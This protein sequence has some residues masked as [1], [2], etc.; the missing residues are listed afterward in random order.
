MAQLAIP[1]AEVHNAAPLL[2]A[3]DHPMFLDYFVGLVGDAAPSRVLNKA[4]SFTELAA[5][6]ETNSDVDLVFMDLS[7]PDIRGLFGLLY[8]KTRYPH[9]RFAVVSGNSSRKTI[10]TCFALGAHSFIPKNTDR[11]GV[12]NA[13][14]HVLEGGIWPSWQQSEPTTLSDEEHARLDAV[15]KLTPQEIKTYMLLCEGMVDKQIA[16]VLDIAPSTAKAHVASILKKLSVFTRTQA[17]IYAFELGVEETM[18]LPEGLL[19]MERK[20]YATNS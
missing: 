9:V 13:V 4:R 12:Q 5:S 11:D 1:V 3:D 18:Y 7:M 17:V 16:K 10:E 19:A 15:R 2:I 14:S 8:L 20:A 6:L